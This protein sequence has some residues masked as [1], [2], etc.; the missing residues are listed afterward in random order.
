MGDRARTAYVSVLSGYMYGAL[1][2]Y[3][4]VF[5]S[6]F[7]ANVPVAFFNGGAV[8]AVVEHGV[9]NSACL[10]TFYTWL[11]VFALLAVPMACLELT[12]QIVVQVVMFAARVLVVLLMTGTVMNGW[13]TC[14]KGSTVF[15]GLPSS[16]TSSTDAI[17]GGGLPPSNMFELTG[18]AGLLPVATYAFI[19]HHSVPVLA[20]PVA[21]KSSLPSLFASAFAVCCIAYGALGLIVSMGFG[22]AINQQC[23]LNWKDYVGCVAAPASGSVT[24]S[25]AT[26]AAVAIRFV[27]LIFPAL[28]VLSA[29]P[30]N[31]ITLGNNLQ[32]ACFQG[33]KPSTSAQETGSSSSPH[34]SS[35]TS[36]SAAAGGEEGAAPTGTP[37]SLLSL[38]LPAQGT[39]SPSSPALS[40]SALAT[41]T[42]FRLLAAVPP[43]L[44]GAA[45]T[46]SG[47]DL[48]QI[49]RWTGL[50]GVAIAFLIPAL[51]RAV[52]YARSKAVLAAL[53][54]QE[55]C[56][57]EDLRAALSRPLTL[58]EVFLDG[59]GGEDRRVAKGVL[60]TPYT[61]WSV[62]TRLW[63]GIRG[64]G[65][66]FVFALLMAVYV[67]WGL[68][69]TKS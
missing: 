65:V 39:S 18:L 43:I 21:V 53:G 59:A 3:G 69:T 68:A 15:A 29:Y 8:C 16:N 1:W 40:P 42:F 26:V 61:S 5:A 63:G 60:R 45:S 48:D 2:A 37:S 32:A 51:L 25:S 50:I 54:R 56:S 11:G 12:E 67:F 17:S 38:C 28:D 44:A 9:V 14:P 20:H 41:R 62:G 22:D 30:L 27:V 10:G 36:S 33:N 66:M 57:R 34:H 47:I 23:N 31:A 55:G 49:L 52:S 13:A 7:A 24:P 46:A 58:Q 19:F 4:T 35:S 64:D 6:S